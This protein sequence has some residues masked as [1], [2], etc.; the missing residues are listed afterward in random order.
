MTLIIED[1]TGIAGANSYVSLD[2]VADYAT[3]RNITDWDSASPD[4]QAAAVVFATDYLDATYRP[5]GPRL[6]A[7]QGL[8]WPTRC[9]EGLAR[10]LVAACCQLAIYALSGPLTAPTTRGI[11]ST[12]KKLDGVGDLET[13]YDDVDTAADPFPHVTAMMSAISASSGGGGLVIGQLTR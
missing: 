9:D 10:C 11:K 8:Q 5:N 2:I 4:A 3:L 6:S 7:S 1:G 12:V 13:V